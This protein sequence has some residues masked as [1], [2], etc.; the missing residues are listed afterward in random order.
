[1]SDDANSKKPDALAKTPDQI[2]GRTVFDLVVHTQTGQ[3]LDAAIAR[4]GAWSVDRFH[5]GAERIRRL[6]RRT[7]QLLVEGAVE[8]PKAIPERVGLEILENVA[9]E[10]REELFEWWAR[11]MVGSARDGDVDASHIDAVKKLNNPSTRVLIAIGNDLDNLPRA[12][13][14]PKRIPDSV[15]SEFMEEL[16]QVCRLTV[17]Q[18][19]NACGRLI[20]LGLI[21][22]GLVPEAERM[23][24]HLTGF[25]V[26]LLTILYPD[27]RKRDGSS[28]LEFLERSEQA[29]ES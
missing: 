20:A 23:P 8:N 15:Y 16:A 22:A 9:R 10:D 7:D 2:V 19:A 26:Q 21:E 6:F 5:V 24:Y 17:E 18:T 4:L 28:L 12:K 1:V 11:L 29:S 13:P 25:G 3:R 27:G 14:L